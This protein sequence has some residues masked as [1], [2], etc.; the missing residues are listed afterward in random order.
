MTQRISTDR[1]DHERWRAWVGS[2]PLAPA[3]LLGR[4]SAAL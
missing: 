2:R 3:V 1:T 4:E